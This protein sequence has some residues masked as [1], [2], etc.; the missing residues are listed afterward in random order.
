MFLLRFTIAIC[1]TTYTLILPGIVLADQTDWMF[2]SLIEN[3]T[4]DYNNLEYGLIRDGNIT[5]CLLKKCALLTK[6]YASFDIPINST[7][8]KLYI[9]YH[10]YGSNATI[11]M[12]DFGVNVRCSQS[13]SLLMSFNPGGNFGNVEDHI[14]EVNNANKCGNWF[15]PDKMNKGNNWQ[16]NDSISIGLTSVNSNGFFGVDD[17]S[18]KAE[19][20]LLSETP[21]P[22][23]SPTPAISPTPSPFLELPWDYESSGKG[24]VQQAFNPESWFD[25]KYPLQNYDYIKKALMFDGIERGVNYRG[26]SGYDYA[27]RNGV[28]Y[29][30]PVLAAAPGMAS[31]KSESQSG[32]LGNLIKI[33]HGN[34]YQTWY[35]HLDGDNHIFA[36]LSADLR[37][38]TRLF[39]EKKQHIGDTGYSGNVYP[40]NQ[41]GSHIHFSVFKDSNMNNNFDDDYPFGLVDPLGWKP[42]SIFAV[43]SDP[44]TEWPGADAERH[45]SESYNLFTKRLAPTEKTVKH[46]E[47][48][49]IVSDKVTLT[50]PKNSFLVNANVKIDNGVFESVDDT[51]ASIVPSLILTARSL[52]G[53]IIE[54]FFEPIQISYDYS[55]ADLTNINQNSVR[56][57]TFDEQSNIWEP[58]NIIS[59]DLDNRIITSETTHF[60]RFALMGEL[61]D[62]TAPKT[63]VI[64]NGKRQESQ[65]YRS[66]IS[67]ELQGKDNEDGTGVDSTLY[68]VDG[69]EWSYYFSPLEF[70]KEGEYEIFY[71]SRDRADNVEEQ[72]S[73]KFYIDK[74][75]PEAEIS[76][77]LDAF[78]IKVT[79]NDDSG[80]ASA[81]A[82]TA[83]P[84][85]PKYIIT[86]QAG[87]TTV[88]SASKVKIG[89]QVALGINSLK[90]ND[91]FIQIDPNVFFT[92]AITDRNNK[93]KQ[94][95]QYY[96]SKNE[97]KVFTLYTSTSNTTKIYSKKT[98]DSTFTRED[99]PGITL[100][101][102]LTNKGALKYS[103]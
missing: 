77:Q 86:D 33:D 74:T 14:I 41:Y 75:P 99:K 53:D 102:L 76:Y 32:G 69:T 96:S 35:G 62:K 55:E 10:L 2:P 70:E 21:T 23:P 50:I 39:V 18:V 88:L 81:K 28:E 12:G 42:D 27:S 103:Y 100:L 4:N 30:T 5:T 92:L 64:I 44:W 58:L 101:K 61:K 57:Y 93:I 91:D 20:V 48:E 29:Q 73:F 54:I 3:G 34:S 31:F 59:H 82:D 78:D 51:L 52:V 37:T 16:P 11:I 26:H 68:S 19:Y 7:I 22:S 56:L 40:K 98:G 94:L 25:H 85:R 49:I 65:W 1:L 83:Q 63:E 71:Q 67:V 97:I 17:I 24:F 38:K 47:E 66:S 60:S 9:R 89:K 8:T 72:K 43:K 15:T 95:D 36:T 6:G 13:P 45:G 90:Y 79:G 46:D 84:L 87:N 80:S